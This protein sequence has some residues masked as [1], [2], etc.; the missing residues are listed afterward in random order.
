MSPKLLNLLKSLQA[1]FSTLTGEKLG[2]SQKKGLQTIQSTSRPD[3]T[4]STTVG[5]VDVALIGGEAVKNKKKGH[6]EDATFTDRKGGSD[7]GYI[8]KK[9]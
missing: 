9:T 7:Q 8:P 3:A 4:S 6:V 1:Q 5:L 2:C